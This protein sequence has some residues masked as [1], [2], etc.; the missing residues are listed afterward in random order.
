M[1]HVVSDLCQQGLVM[2]SQFEIFSAVNEKGV[3]VTSSRDHTSG[4]YRMF[5]SSDGDLQPSIRF[6]P[7]YRGDQK[8]DRIVRINLFIH[9]RCSGG[10]EVPGLH[11]EARKPGIYQNLRFSKNGQSEVRTPFHRAPAFADKSGSFLEIRIESRRI[12]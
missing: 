7:Q 9:D 10:I 1:D 8:A 12:S 3:I 11:Q 2:S 4:R 5:R 6:C